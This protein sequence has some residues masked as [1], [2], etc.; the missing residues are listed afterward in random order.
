MKGPQGQQ[1]PGD[2][3]GNAV[4]VA[5]IAT[6]EEQE[7]RKEAANIGRLG[8]LARARNL[9]PERRSEIARQA[10]AARQQKRAETLKT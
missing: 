2:V 5:R 10:N 4:A 8:G 3:V 9:S 6:G 7:A 1:R